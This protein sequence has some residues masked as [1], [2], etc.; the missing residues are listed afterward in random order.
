MAA[1]TFRYGTSAASFRLLL[2][3]TVAGALEISQ[4]TATTHS[5]PSEVVKISP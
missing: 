1:T 3:A 5:I 4:P 2:F